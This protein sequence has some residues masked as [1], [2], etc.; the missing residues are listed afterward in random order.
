MALDDLLRAI[1][2][3]AR[4][5]RLRADRERAASA[6]AIVEA[7]RR[8]AAA[9]VEQ[10]AMAP[11]AES[12]AAAER[13]RA[14]ARLQA[15]DAVRGAR[16]QAYASLL[17][18]VRDQ[19]SALRQSERYPEVFRAL[20]DE[21]RAALPEAD[22]LRVDR[23]DAELAASMAGDLRVVAVLD[24]WGGLELAGDDGRTIRNTLEERLANADLA[25]RERFARR[26]DQ[27]SGAEAVEIS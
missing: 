21:S 3:E 10:L 12:L 23:R 15:A 14:L 2:S 4:E 1:E 9:L 5:E 27:G 22:E 19:L 18:Q 11:E 8:E 24:T 16:E 25:L 17:G 20:L 26:L 6:K 13:V 7:A